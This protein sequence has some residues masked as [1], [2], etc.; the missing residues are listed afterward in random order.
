[1]YSSQL[2]IGCRSFV[3]GKGAISIN[4]VLVAFRR[5]CVLSPPGCMYMYIMVQFRSFAI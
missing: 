1:V 5:L 3:L 2:S 4:L